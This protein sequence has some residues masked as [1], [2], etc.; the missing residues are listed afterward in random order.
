M[1]NAD[2]FTLHVYGALAQRERELISVRTKAALKALKEKGTAK[3]GAVYVAG[4][5]ENFTAE[6]R[7]KGVA[8]SAAIR[9]AKADKFSSMIAP[10]INEYRNAGTSFAG[11]AGKLN[12]E[13]LKTRRGGEWSAVTVSRVCNEVNA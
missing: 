8:K 7:S 13:G 5:I 11:I 4:K 6:G 2:S 9:T 10:K 1:P 3:A 12:A